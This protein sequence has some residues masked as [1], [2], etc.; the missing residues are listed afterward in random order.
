MI[1]IEFAWWKKPPGTLEEDAIHPPLHCRFLLKTSA[2]LESTMNYPLSVPAT[3]RWF[4]CWYLVRVIYG[5]ACLSSLYIGAGLK[6]AEWR[7]TQVRPS[8]MH[9][10]QAAAVWWH[11]VRGGGVAILSPYLSLQ[12]M[13]SNMLRI[14]FPS[15][16][17]IQLYFVSKFTTLGTLGNSKVT[18]RQL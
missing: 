15:H 10:G 5:P 13:G 17:D 16:Y 9:S 3:P 2:P 14:G 1:P 11:L 7:E 8:K 18:W 4:I 12:R 6:W